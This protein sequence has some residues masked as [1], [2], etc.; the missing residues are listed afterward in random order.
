MYY[1]YRKIA[2]YMQEHYFS[3][4]LDGEYENFVFTKTAPTLLMI[5]G[6]LSIGILIACFIAVFERRYIGR[7]LRTL[8]ARGATD[9]EH[10]LT[11]SEMGLAG[12]GLLK[13]E[14]SRAGVTRKLIAV[15]DAD[16][17]VRDYESE[18]RAAFPE[19][20]ARLDDE[21]GILAE[22]GKS[23]ADTETG[24]AIIAE[25]DMIGGADTAPAA[26]EQTARRAA[27][28]SRHFKLRP[29]DFSTARFFIPEDLKFRAELRSRAKGSS[30]WMLVV[31]TVVVIAFFLLALFFIPAF[32]NM[33][34][35]TISNLRGA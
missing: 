18:L 26:T 32:V 13:R 20:A 9:A 35:I 12:K 31:A 33:L 21:R 27:A 5:V 17:T 16:G 25:A 2:I 8:L 22:K 34:D 3:S 15:V 1:L 6:G 24:D 30:P 7:F 23:D 29:V 11:L 19:Y 10:A 14:I 4:N 28:P